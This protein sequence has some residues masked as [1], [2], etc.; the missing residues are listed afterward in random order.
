LN[1][2]GKNRR[3]LAQTGANGRVSAHFGA[4]RRELVRF[5]AFRPVSLRFGAPGGR[6]RTAGTSA[7]SVLIAARRTWPPKVFTLRAAET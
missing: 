4:F 5:G 1:V 2:K 7:C 3:Q 6:L